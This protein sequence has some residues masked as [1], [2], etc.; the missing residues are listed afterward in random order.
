MTQ[1][2][3]SP[4]PEPSSTRHAMLQVC[5][6]VGLLCLTV[7]FLYLTFRVG[8][9]GNSSTAPSA[10]PSPSP[11]EIHRFAVDDLSP[12]AA[13]LSDD[14]DEG[15]L[16]VAP[17]ADWYVAPRDKK[18]LVQFLWMRQSALPR[19]TIEANEASFPRLRDVTV[20]KLPEFREKFIAALDESTRQAVD[21]NALMLILGDIP[22]L[23]YSMNK[24]FRLGTLEYPGERQVL[25]TLRKGRLYTVTL[26][27]QAGGL[28]DRNGDA[29]AVVAG[30]QFV[31]PAAS[32]EKPSD[33][34]NKPADGARG[35][36]DAGR[37]ESKPDAS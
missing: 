34:A 26:D 31:E 2:P 5:L 29:F 21:E 25:V 28:V 13:Y 37:A 11:P 18:Y 27:V 15:R 22:C 8:R 16:R 33:E 6:A 14:L 4:A 7:L 35:A 36:T 20:A 9:Q 32:N 17:P 30:L 23:A 12:L 3:A 10:P 19:I 1:D 24:Q